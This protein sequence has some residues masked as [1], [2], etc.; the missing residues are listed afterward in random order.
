MKSKALLM[1]SSVAKKESLAASSR[2]KA[3]KSQ[4]PDFSFKIKAMKMPSSGSDKKSRSIQKRRFKRSRASLKNKSSPKM[5]RARDA[6]G[7]FVKKGKGTNGDMSQT[8]YMPIL[9]G[10]DGKSAEAIVVKKENADKVDVTNVK[11]AEK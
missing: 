9:Q 3:L 1:S 7:R 2:R 5:V 11:I 10:S 4:N 8:I 6:T